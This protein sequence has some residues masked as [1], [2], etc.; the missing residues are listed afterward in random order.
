MEGERKKYLSE[1]RKEEREE[2]EEE[3]EEEAR[4]RDRWRRWEGGATMRVIIIYC[5]Y[6]AIVLCTAAQ[7]ST[8]A[9]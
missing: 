9:V 1:R 8:T 6:T 5:H 3:E 4:E 2:E 7:L